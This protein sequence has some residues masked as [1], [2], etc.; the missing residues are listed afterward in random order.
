MLEDRFG[1]KHNYLRIS[2]TERCNLRCT[3]CMPEE[4][5]PLTPKDELLTREEIV[6]IVR[7]FVEQGVSKLR[8]TGGEPLI[9][10]DLEGI[11]EDLAPLREQGL[12][13]TIAMT[14]N[15]IA[16]KRRLPG[17]VERG[18]T[19]VN[20]SLDTMDEHMFTIITRRKGFKQVMDAIDQALVTPG[21]TVKVNCVVTK[22]T[23]E[24]ELIPF[25]EWTKDKDLEVRFI[26]YM[27]FDGNRWNNNKFLSFLEMQDIIRAKYPSL[28]RMVEEASE[29][30]K[31]FHVPGWNGRVGFITSMSKNFCA[32]CNRLRVTADG[33]LK[34]C[35][36][37]ATEQS[38]R[39][40]LRDNVESD[41]QLRAL[42]GAAVQRKKPRHAG[43]FEIAK[44]KNRPMITIGG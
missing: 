38:L 27:P 40:V 11:L 32:G 36:F 7:V 14:T 34:V 8:F 3:Y 41:D 26:E 25:V 22:G 2:L 13:T 29:T 5:V 16:L 20:I 30:S 1:R 18:L 24:R 19:H 39:D 33:N 21:L 31:V 15:A 4:G 42:I 12:L 28:T 17:L 35:L 43:M 6:R 23:S 10:R 37:G 9:R 44:S